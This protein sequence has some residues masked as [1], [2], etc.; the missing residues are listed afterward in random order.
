[1][2]QT[3]IGVFGRRT[4][5]LVAILTLAIALPPSQATT[6]TWRPRRLTTSRM[7][8]SRSGSSSFGIAVGS[9]CGSHA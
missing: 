4:G 5:Q 6:Q 3:S 2:R 1:M 9:K 7:S 8:I